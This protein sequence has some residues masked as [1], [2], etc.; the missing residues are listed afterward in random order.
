MAM[1]PACDCGNFEKRSDEQ[2]VARVSE[3]RGRDTFLQ[4]EPKS[5][6]QYRPRQPAA[7]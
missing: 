7:G 1:D 6:A 5:F 3:K 2:R 4:N